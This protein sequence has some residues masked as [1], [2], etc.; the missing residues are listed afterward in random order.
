MAALLAPGFADPVHQSQ[1]AFRA[2][3][4][5]MS[6]PGTAVHVPSAEA[7][8]PMGPGMAAVALTLCD[9]DT[10]LWL[11][12]TFGD[13]VSRWL[14]FHTGAPVVE[15]KAKAQFVFADAV[16]LEGLRVGE[17]IYPDRSATLVV[18]V[19]FAGPSVTL[20]GPGIEGTR[21][22]TAVLPEGFEAAWSDNRALYPCGVDLVLADGAR[23]MALPR[24]TEV[25]CTLR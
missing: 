22:T 12:P 3:L 4:T 6:E 8:Y 20:K 16:N 17:P 13:E 24:T 14:A 18:E 25:L 2:L 7:P 21:T 15:D 10:P 1:Q 11:A 9:A 5:A 23:L 19:A